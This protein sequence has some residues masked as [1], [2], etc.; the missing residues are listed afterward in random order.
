[1]QLF[2]SIQIKK[3]PFLKT[4]PFHHWSAS[5]HGAMKLLSAQ[6]TTENQQ[7]AIN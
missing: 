7:Q 2:N 1:L 3:S 4:A 5:F 6:T